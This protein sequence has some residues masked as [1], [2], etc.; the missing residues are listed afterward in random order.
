MAFRFSLQK[1]LDIK[2]DQLAAA[3]KQE[4]FWRN[5]V[6]KIERRIEILRLAYL[7][8]R[9]ALNTQ[10]AGSSLAERPLFEASLEA[11]KEDIMKELRKLNSARAQLAEWSSRALE[12]R[13]KT[14]GLE[15]VRARRMAEFHRKAEEVLQ[16]EI[17]NRA[18]L[19]A[20]KNRQEDGSL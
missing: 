8:D 18:A 15:K 11:K 17:D 12:L 13:K 6:G 1:I 4:T 10:I 20:W 2:L 9:E 19:R 7:A 3:E 16:K 14:R 5:E